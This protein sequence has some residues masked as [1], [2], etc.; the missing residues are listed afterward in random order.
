MERRKWT[1]KYSFII[2]KIPCVEFGKDP[3]QKNSKIC[4]ILVVEL[5]EA[6]L[7]LDI[8]WSGKNR[9]AEIVFDYI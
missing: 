3:T 1:G 7:R 9:A 5:N 8:Y 2:S 6:N 4:V